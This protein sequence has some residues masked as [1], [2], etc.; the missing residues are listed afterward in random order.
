MLLC[1]HFLNDS[2]PRM[3][4]VQL[5]LEK[6]LA[7]RQKRIEHTGERGQ[8]RLDQELPSLLSSLHNSFLDMAMVVEESREFKQESCPQPLAVLQ[9]VMPIAEQRISDSKTAEE[10]FAAIKI[11]TDLLDPFMEQK[12]WQQLSQY[13]YNSKFRNNWSDW[14]PESKI[15]RKA[16]ELLREAVS[17][18]RNINVL[19]MT[20]RDGETA[21]MYKNGRD[22]VNLYAVDSFKNIM[23]TDRP[24]FKRIIYGALKGALITRDCFDVVLCAPYISKDRIMRGSVYVKQEK[25]M[26][27]RAIDYLRIGGVLLLALPYYRFYKD[28][29]ELL[30]KN[31][32]NFQLFTTMEEIIEGPKFI[33]IMCQRKK[34]EIRILDNDMYII[35]RT[36][37][38]HSGDTVTIDPEELNRIKL[39]QGFI[40]VQRFRGSELN[41]QEIEELYNV[42]RCT[43]TFWKDQQVEKLGEN[44]AHPLLPFNVGQLG[45]VLTSGCLDGIID[46]GNGFYH[47]V[48]GRVIKRNDKTESIDVSS[49]QVQVINTTSNRVEINAFLPDGTFK[50]L[51]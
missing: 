48:K 32:E 11:I 15:S 26:I 20:A 24:Q 1:M 21:S 7:I 47:A 37:P 40:E 33:Y 29:C 42:S 14:S 31:F 45:L 9:T 34:A 28:I 22:N 19:D 8:D 27:S 35:L 38:L 43:K 46:E 18:G 36:L 17:T 4:N 10:L 51:A 44:K 25:E 41:E 12:K 16:I 13:N 30:L 2:Y 3:K 39:P 50:C 23:S 49:N 6:G 5:K